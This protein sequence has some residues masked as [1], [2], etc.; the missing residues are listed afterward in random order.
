[1]ELAKSVTVKVTG[2]VTS[3]VAVERQIRHALICI[4]V[5]VYMITLQLKS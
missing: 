2:D 5:T 4:N 3:D 1:M